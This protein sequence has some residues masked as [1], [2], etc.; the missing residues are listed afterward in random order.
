LKRSGIKGI[1]LNILKEMYTKQIA[2][3]KLSGEKLKRNSTKTRDRIK[4]STL[5]TSVQ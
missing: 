2:S 4:L 1:Y 3:I 5:S